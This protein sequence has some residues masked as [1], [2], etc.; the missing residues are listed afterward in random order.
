[1]KNDIEKIIRICFDEFCD[2]HDN[3]YEC[4]EY[5]ADSNDCFEAYKEDKLNQ[6][7]LKGGEK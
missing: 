4:P 1:M 6:L 2:S 3:C 5:I 7:K